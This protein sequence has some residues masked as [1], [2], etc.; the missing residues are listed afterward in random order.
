M[1][2]KSI[3]ESIENYLIGTIQGAYKTKRYWMKK[4]FTEENAINK[5]ITY[6]I[7]QI[8]SGIG[9]TYTLQ[10]VENMFREIGDIAN[11]LADSC[12]QANENQSV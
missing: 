12:K 5:S 8:Q 3:N 4:R 9:E 7:H 2:V 11:A 10:D 1:E 6:A